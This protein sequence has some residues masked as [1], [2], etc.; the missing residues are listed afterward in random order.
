VV[1]VLGF[2]FCFCFCASPQHCVL[3]L[4]AHPPLARNGGVVV[5]VAITKSR[6]FNGMGGVP[7][8]V[9]RKEGVLG[10]FLYAHIY[11]DMRICAVNP[12]PATPVNG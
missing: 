5:V 1:R 11:V 9:V 4:G 7:R 6:A 2:R 3:V 8:A 12:T 10:F